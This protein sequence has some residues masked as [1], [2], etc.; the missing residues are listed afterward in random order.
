MDERYLSLTAEELNQLSI[1]ASE[2]EL[3]HKRTY[4]YDDFSDFFG[5]EAIDKALEYDITHMEEFK[6]E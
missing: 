1:D 3:E 4:E 6:N 5:Y 2:F